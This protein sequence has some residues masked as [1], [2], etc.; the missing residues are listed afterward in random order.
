MSPDEGWLCSAAMTELTVTAALDHLDSWKLALRA[1]NKAPGTIAVYADC[2]TRYLRWCAETDQLPMSRASL[3]TWVAGMLDG[4]NAPGTARIRQQAV[5]R[6][7]TWLT[8]GGD[9]PSNPFPGMKAPRVQTP[10]VEPFTD[11]ELRALIRTCAVPELEE[12]ATP[13]AHTLHHRRD[14]AIIRL[15]FETAIRSGEVADLHLD[16]VDL[17]SRLITI[18]RGK[19]GR[20]RV[21]PIGQATTEALLRYLAEREQHPRAASPDLWLGNRGKQFGREGL[22]RALRRR[23]TRAGVQGFRP[24]RLRHTAAHRWLAAGGSESG[25]MAIAGWTRTD[26][27]IRYTRARASER[28]AEEARRLNLGA[29]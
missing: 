7:A 12:G 3:N 5:R 26:M 10:L 22:S 13:S 29:I 20:G 2:A 11:N 16:D 19:G 14:E 15:M 25:L 4:G 18:R 24:H 1:E 28:A 8:A 17:I 21:I 23:A 9:I 27:L 6:F